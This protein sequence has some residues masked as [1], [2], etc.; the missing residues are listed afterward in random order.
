[1]SSICP[2]LI[3]E[4]PTT[5]LRIFLGAHP[6]LS[7][8]KRLTRQLTAVY[9]WY[10]TR[11]RVKEQANEFMELDL[12]SV[13]AET[14]LRYSHVFFVRRQVHQAIVEKQ[15]QLLDSGKPP[16][17]ADAAVLACLGDC[18]AEIAPRLHHEVKQLT[19]VKRHCKIPFRRELDPT[20]PFENAD[21]LCM[22]RCAEEDSCADV[23]VENKCKQFIDAERVFG[24][25][26]IVQRALLPDGKPVDK[27]D[28][29]LANKYLLPDYAKVG[30]APKL[31]PLD[32]TTYM[33]FVGERSVASDD[34]FAR[35]VWGHIFR[36]Y[37]TQPSVL[38][39]CG[40]YAGADAS[41]GPAEPRGD[42]NPLTGQH[43]LGQLNASL[44]EQ[45]CRQ[46]LLFP[47]IKLR[48]QYL[49]CGV[50]LA[51]QGWVSDVCVPT[52][53]LFPLMGHTMAEDLLARI[54]VGYFFHK[55]NFEPTAN[56]LDEAVTRRV[57]DF[58]TEVISA[59]ESSAESL[60][61]QA[62]EGVRAMAPPPTDEE[63]AA[64]TAALND[65][66]SGAAAADGASKAEA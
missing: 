42:V 16:K 51:R 61:Q 13:D 1:M 64:V 46:Q 29:R 60:L 44:A 5:A 39:Y 35:A 36:R 48:S 45:A 10:A 57:R 65:A 50:E 30:W 49:Y 62:L 15:L 38:Q 47:A 37:A 11:R 56:L 26:G 2:G 32:V 52:L 8:E 54:V 23:D 27:K 22:M 12:A 14:M 17:L 6:N 63:R 58:A 55:A 41:S 3:G 24:V 20:A 4:A 28:T 9:P 21:I 34:A 53:R 59:R 18:N 25:A 66:E 19:T 33:R 7:V 40:T 31:R 43:V